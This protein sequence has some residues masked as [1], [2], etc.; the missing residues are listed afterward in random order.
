[1]SGIFQHLMAFVTSVV[2][3]PFWQYVTLLLHGNG[4][5][6][7]QNN[8]FI[9]SSTNNFS[10]TRNGSPTQG[11]ISPYGP[12]WSAY[13]NTSSS[14]T[15]YAASSGLFAIGTSNF[16]VEFWAN[17]NTW[18]GE[19]RLIVMGVSGSSSIEIGRTSAGG[20]TLYVTINNV[21]KF[22][23]SFTPVI[24]N[25][26]HIAL[27]RSGTAAS[28]LILYI[29]GVNAGSGTSADSIAANNFFIGGISW[30]A[31]YN[32][33]G[34]ISNVR[35]NNGV[36]VYTSTFTTPTAPLP[37]ITGTVLLTCQSAR[38]KDNS[39]NNFS[40]LTT[41]T[42]SVQRFSPFS[43]GTAYSASVIGGSGYFNGT[44][45][46][47]TLPTNTAFDLGTLACSV[48]AWVYLAG[49]TASYIFATSSNVN[50]QTRPNFSVK[51][52]QIQLDYYGLVIIT[53]AP[54]ITQNTWNH[55]VFTRASTNGP[56]RI[57]LNG[58]L[59]AYNATGTQNLLQ[60][61]APQLINSLD[62]T[63][64]TQCYISGLQIVK[65][66]VPSAYVTSS[67]TIN[68]Q[69]FTPP[70]APITAASGSSLLLNFI[71]GVGIYDNAM[72]N[73]LVTVSTAQ[74]STAQ[75]KFGGSSMYF[76]GSSYLTSIDRTILQL[77]SGDFTIEGW[78]YL[79]AIN[80]TY[81]IICKGAATTGFSVNVTSGNK[82]QFSYATSNLTGATSLAASTWYYFAVVRSGSATGN[83]IIYLNGTADATSGSAIT[84]NF[85]QTDILYAGA[86]RVGT[87]ILNGYVNDLR[88]TKGIARS[89]GLPA[90]QFPDY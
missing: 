47:L 19:Q 32:I 20:N 42:P 1:M 7:A 18:S 70:T 84:D 43:M 53:A 90:T 55:V 63:T 51:T 37:T 36:A 27:V 88:I 21:Q 85:N 6:G 38:F 24:N 34:Y 10:V 12:D 41:G 60:G 83:V 52:N 44:T 58:V 65:G 2:T 46:Y 23:A 54:T 5:N 33:L 68:A 45:D 89:I 25:W 9:D 64:T 8:T 56:W 17:W 72:Q 71:S 75:S 26:Y 59:L 73:N 29:N 31:G 35:F 28:Q 82:L 3:D 48:E 87:S 16:T 79:N 14:D 11:T 80:V 78:I 67:T 86:G 81:G 61:G 66:A 57:F 50:G 39:G 30:A 40:I 69:I 76:N 22:T 62:A 74:I 15:I 13:L 77:G 49:T 4:T